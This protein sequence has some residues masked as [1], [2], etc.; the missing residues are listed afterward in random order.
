MMLLTDERVTIGRRTENRLA[1]QDG[2][3][4]KIH[5]TIHR[6]GQDWYIRDWCS[7]NGTL[8]NN[9][10]IAEVKLEDGDQ[11]SIGNTSI[12]FHAAGAPAGVGGITI[13]PQ[14]DLVETI[15]ACLT[16]EPGDFMPEW[17]ISNEKELRD[18]YQRLR[19]A[20]LFNSYMRRE[21]DEKN[22]IQNI[23]RFA[24]ELLPADRGAILLREV[25]GAPLVPA[26]VLHRDSLV[27]KENDSQA[28]I[29]IPGSILRR[30]VKER[31]A[32]LSGDATVDLRFKDSHSILRENVRS[33]MCVPL[34]GRQE[35]LGAIHLDTREQTG[36][37]SVKDL[38]LLST[39]GGQAATVIEQARLH[40]RLE[41]E[42]ITRERLSRF[43]PRELIQEVV[44]RGID[45]TSKGRT[46]RATV[47]FCDIR[48]FSS[49]AE[50]MDPTQL[51]RMLNA[52]FEQMVDVVFRHNGMLDKFIGDALMAVWGAPIQQRY[53]ARQALEAGR[54]IIE[55]VKLF[56][57]GGRSHGWPQLQVGVGVNT[58]EAVI[59]A[60]GSSR[61]MEYTVM[62]DT[63][64]LAAR[65]C[66]QAAEGQVLVTAETLKEFEEESGKVPQVNELPPVR[67]RGRKSPVSM[68]ELLEI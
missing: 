16:C 45:L 61:R 68:S 60:V 49:L 1:L 41:K 66:D 9:Q 43:L 31:K 8:V 54:D 12:L 27:D 42:A 24:F 15:Q 3:V 52:F 48:G 7:A 67:V 40:G 51:V 47:L 38:Q 29:V 14:S 63:V 28:E 32:V 2:Q 25:E 56:N 6:E 36:A 37:F 53:G 65:V 59:G 58:G 22:L 4:S 50:S 64:N 44:E 20:Y 62:G 11:V 19:T 17:D 30:A 26:V 5:A 18:D 13:V 57:M 34:V 33:A 55:A 10:P 46:G 39:L 21:Q 23:L 35:V